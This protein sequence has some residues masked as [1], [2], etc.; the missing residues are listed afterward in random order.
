M[1]QMYEVAFQTHY[2][3]LID[4][5]KVVVCADSN[6]KASEMVCFLFDLP[7][8]RTVFDVVRIKPSI[9]QISRKEVSKKARRKSINHNLKEN[10]NWEISC[11]VGVRAASECSAL[12]RLAHAIIDRSTSD[13]AIID[14]SITEFELSCD[15]IENRPK[16]SAV[17][18]QGIYKEKKFFP[19]GMAR[20][21]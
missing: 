15:R 18:K 3:D 12:R 5:G 16:L 11:S 6:E 9:F 17:E 8:S 14:K 20:P 10:T 13:K 1:A 4:I 7:A 2:E 21:R 19:G